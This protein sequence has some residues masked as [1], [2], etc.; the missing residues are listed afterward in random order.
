ML[1]YSYITIH[2]HTKYDIEVD[3]DNLTCNSEGY[4]N[5]HTH[6]DIVIR[7][8]MTIHTHT[9]TDNVIQTA[10]TIHIHTQIM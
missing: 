2:I 7:R 8:A 3:M 1:F 10:M 6:T 5:T 9:H 4:D